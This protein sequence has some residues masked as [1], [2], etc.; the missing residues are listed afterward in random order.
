MGFAIDAQFS[1]SG[2][3]ALIVSLKGE[4]W[5]IDLTG[6]LPRQLKLFECSDE[7]KKGQLVKLSGDGSGVVVMLQGETVNSDSTPV[8]LHLAPHEL[9]LQVLL[10]NQ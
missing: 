10:D 7:A 5:L 2:D 8:F 4:V 6:T 1:Q 9:D 3:R